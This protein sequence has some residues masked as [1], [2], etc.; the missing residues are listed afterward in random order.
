MEVCTL[1]RQGNH[2][3]P[4]PCHYSKAFAFSILLYLHR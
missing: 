4:Y 1:S 2:F 3:I